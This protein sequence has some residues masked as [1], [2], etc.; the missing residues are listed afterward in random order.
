MRARCWKLYLLTSLCWSL[1]DGQ[2]LT[3]VHRWRADTAIEAAQWVEVSQVD[4][5]L[6]FVQMTRWHVFERFL[7]CI[8]FSTGTDTAHQSPSHR[9]A[10][11]FRCQRYPSFRQSHDGV[12]KNKFNCVIIITFCSQCM[13]VLFSRAGAAVVF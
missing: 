11:R 6:T 13:V 10:V 12:F 8:Y 3:R 4:A 5:S 7:F 9:V 1:S 2:P